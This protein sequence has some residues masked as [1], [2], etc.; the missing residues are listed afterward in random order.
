[1]AGNYGGVPPLI[2][3]MELKITRFLLVFFGLM[4]I[5]VAYQETGKFQHLGFAVAV[6]VYL[7]TEP[8]ELSKIAIR[9]CQN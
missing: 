3:D 4:I 6:M 2:Y 8:I 9:V 7:S 5:I 1:M